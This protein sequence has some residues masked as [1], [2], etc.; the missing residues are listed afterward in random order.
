MNGNQRLVSLKW[1]KVGQKQHQGRRQVV[2]HPA[3]PYQAGVVEVLHSE[4]QLQQSLS[5]PTIP[6]IPFSEKVKNKDNFQNLDSEKSLSEQ[7]NKKL[8]QTGVVGVADPENS[9]T[10]R[11]VDC[12]TSAI[13]L[14]STI[15]WQSYPYQS[16][17]VCTL[18]DRANKVK[19][20]VLSC[21][22]S[23]ELIS[24]YADGKISHSEINWLKSYLLTQQECLQLE[25]IE[26]RKQLNLFT[27]HNEEPTRA[28]LKK[29][30]DTE[31]KRIRWSKQ[32]GLDYIQ[33]KYSVTSRQEMSIEQLIEFHQYLQTLPI[34]KF[35]GNSVEEK[36]L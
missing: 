18:K 9:F 33:N 29:Q 32:I 36:K 4:T 16:K 14:E 11:D 13:P 34:A 7:S 22:T 12:N 5:T 27:E 1:T 35:G 21:T 17:D 8:G 30:I 10:I 20:R 19:E 26:K 15:L 6:A 31:A 23:N 25:A 3:I 28:Q 2:W 24:L